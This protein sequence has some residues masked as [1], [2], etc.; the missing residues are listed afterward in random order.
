VAV[1]TVPDVEPKGIVISLAGT[2]RHN[3]IGST[4]CAHL[5]QRVVEHGLAS[6]RLDYSGVGDSPGLVPAWTLSDVEAAAQQARAALS[7][8]MDALGVGR[9]AAVGTCYGSR[10]ALSLVSEQSCVGAV[11]LAP[12][13]LEHGGVSRVSRQVGERT[14]L[15]LVRSHAALRR[16]ARPLRSTMRARRPAGIV[17]DALEHLERARIAFLYGTPSFDDH[18]RRARELLDASVSKLDHGREP[19]GCACCPVGP[20]STFD[21]LRPP[22]SAPC[23]M[24]SCLV[25]A[26]F[27]DSTQDALQ[28]KA[29]SA[30]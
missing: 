20:L 30:P 18:Y 28:A 11:C 23:W 2:G 14:V 17:V 15:S 8:A 26:S 7:V 22:T 25:R 3:V 29:V 27:E 5:S 13:V 16:L 19:P 21:A 12:P 4:M 9:F 6:V 10:V 1:L 24:S